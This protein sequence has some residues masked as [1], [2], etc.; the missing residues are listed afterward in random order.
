VD[1][2]WINKGLEVP[3]SF[4]PDKTKPT[5]KWTGTL[6]VIPLNVG[7]DVPTRPTSDFDYPIIGTPTKAITTAAD[8]EAAD[9]VDEFA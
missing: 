7:G 1:Y 3:F 2:S 6:R 9:A 8:E 4:T 5:T